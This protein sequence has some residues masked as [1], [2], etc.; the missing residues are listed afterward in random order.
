MAAP[1]ILMNNSERQKSRR[2][3]SG[4]MMLIAGI[5]FVVAVVLNT[6]TIAIV[7]SGLAAIV[8]LAGGIS[9]LIA[10]SSQRE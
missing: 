10:Y 1:R 4:V 3:Q 5:L 9:K 2:L 8:C 6:K 7:S